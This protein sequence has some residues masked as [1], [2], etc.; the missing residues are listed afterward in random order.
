MY[1]FLLKPCSPKPVFAHGRTMATFCCPQLPFIPPPWCLALPQSWH[2]IT[3]TNL[4]FSVFHKNAPTRSP[5]R[6]QDKYFPHVE[7]LS[8]GE[9]GG[10]SQRHEMSA[11]CFDPHQENQLKDLHSKKSFIWFPY[12]LDLHIIKVSK[13]GTIQT[14]LHSPGR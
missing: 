10:C 12:G 11:T 2:I 6:G 13:S 3:G 9:G 8:W 7:K 14:L 1:K 4:F 5:E